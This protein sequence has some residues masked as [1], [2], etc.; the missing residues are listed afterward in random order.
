MVTLGTQDYVPDKP[1]MLINLSGEVCSRHERFND[2]REIVGASDVDRQK[3][4]NC[5]REYQSLGYSPQTL[6][7]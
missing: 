7:L 1:D 6:K 2:I 5:Y 3:G 4:R